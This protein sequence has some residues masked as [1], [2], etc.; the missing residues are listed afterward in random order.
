MSLLNEM[1]RNLDKRRQLPDV[2]RETL[3]ANRAPRRSSWSSTP[4]IF[5]FLLAGVAAGAWFLLDQQQ[6][7][8]QVSLVAQK[9]AAVQPVTSPMADAGN[10]NAQSALPVE[11]AATTRKGRGP[12][13][14]PPG[15]EPAIQ[16]F[17]PA[18][19]TS[20]TV[21]MTSP[22]TSNLE[23]D[24]RREREISQLLQ[25]A[26]IALTRVRLT[27]PV[28]D[29]AYDRYL[30]VLDLEPGH[31]KAIS[32]IDYIVVTYVHLIRG[33][34]DTNNLQRAR[35]LLE[36]AQ[37]VR[38]ALPSLV[39]LSRQLQSAEEVRPALTNTD[40]TRVDVRQESSLLIS[41]NRLQEEVNSLLQ[42][43]APLEARDLLEQY[44]VAHPD[45]VITIKRLFNLY[46]QL[47]AIAPAEQLLLNSPQLSPVTSIEL[48]AQLRVQHGD[49]DGAISLLESA[50]PPHNE[51]GYYALLAGLYQTMGRFEE[52]ASHYSQLLDSESVQGTY[53]LGLAVSLDSL[54]DYHGALS[55]FERARESEQYAGDVL[56]Y[57]EQRILALSSR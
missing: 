56:A 3:V 22:S 46:L 17:S 48:G 39:T 20:D 34:L 24:R 42:N 25:S 33:Y 12:E 36:R 23:R 31:S 55:A 43:N 35:L 30:R 5:L 16:L 52:A 50:A 10:S 2:G 18:V 54:L 27:F 8:P 7:P 47:G 51:T 21:P 57:I 19:I 26:D 11:A 15:D 40:A 13:L 38:G 1:L 44:L 29:N 53:W 4:F 6:T 32:G 9:P 37:R 45:S 14:P 49:F 28:E 41:E